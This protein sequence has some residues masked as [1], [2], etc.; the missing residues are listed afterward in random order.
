MKGDEK[1]IA[2]KRGA[3]AGADPMLRMAD[4]LLVTE[5]IL[6]LLWLVGV[7]MVDTVAL[8]LLLFCIPAAGVRLAP[9]ILLGAARLVRRWRPLQPGDLR[10]GATAGRLP[11]PVVLFSREREGHVAILGR[12]GSGKSTMM[13]TL[14]RQDIQAGRKV[15]LI[16]PHMQL[17][18]SMAHTCLVNRKFPILVVTG[19]PW[20]HSVNLL[21]TDPHWTALDA[22]RCITDGLVQ[23]YM[24]YHDELPMR[25]RHVL[26]CAAYFLAAANEGYTLLEIPRFLRSGAFRDHLA[27]KVLNRNGGG[28]D[29]ASLIPGFS[30]GWLED[31]NRT[32]LHEQVQST[33]TRILALLSPPDA[34]R[35]IGCSK[36]TFS[37]EQI[38]E[39]TPLLI[40]I[41]EHGLH[42]SAHLLNALLTTWLTKRLLAGKAG[43]G[44]SD[45]IHMYV[46]E[47]AE[48]SPESFEQLLHRA[49]KE[50]V[51]LTVIVQAQTMLD[52]NLYQALMGNVSNLLIFG[53]SGP[54]VE[55][56]ACEISRPLAGEYRDGSGQ[57]LM[58]L[59]RQ[60]HQAAS[61][62]RDLMPHEFMLH[63]A[64]SPY[65]ALHCRTEL[66]P[67]VDD[68]AVE[69][70][71]DLALSARGRS[72]EIIESEIMLRQSDLDQ[73][74]GCICGLGP[75]PGTVQTAPW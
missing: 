24:P 21:Q 8:M 53:S 73:R 49:R 12:T 15:I 26:E 23:V 9:I 31:L 71:V 42:R 25:I 28:K 19:T 59:Q 56:L 34:Q 13:E 38:R 5:A 57:H 72:T 3:D 45:P 60:L 33:W 35:L 7:P 20:M 40:G 52:R 74:F 47:L 61:D 62:L 29:L 44:T 36:S 75:G 58:E 11:I 55:E 27:E 67:R 54:G 6:L 1:M 37:F 16:D 51:R 65:P 69:G 10:L 63:R 41:G 46:D 2:S 4:I 66:P 64:T 39:G 70:A 43:L 50:S 18:R 68:R 14:V 48:I 17:A 22:A 32:Q 30:L